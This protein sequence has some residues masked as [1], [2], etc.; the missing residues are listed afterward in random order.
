MADSDDTK[1][2]PTQF[3]IDT[4]VFGFRISES[5]EEHNYHKNQVYETKE[6][7]MKKSSLESSKVMKFFICL[8]NIMTY[9]FLFFGA[10]HMFS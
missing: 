9:F 3:Q 6:D 1:Y 2:Y 7:I 10:H 5:V 8:G 4:D